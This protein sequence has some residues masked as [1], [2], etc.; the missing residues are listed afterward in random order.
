MLKTIPLRIRVTDAQHDIIKLKAQMN[1]YSSISQFIR[2]RL[3]KISL[4]AE[5][6]LVEIHEMLQRS[7]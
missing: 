4:E 1:G 7:N 6:Q 5:R 2:D 3:I